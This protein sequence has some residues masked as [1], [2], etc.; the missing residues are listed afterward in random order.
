MRLN[1]GFPEL[2]PELIS[3][4]GLELCFKTFVTNEVFLHVTSRFFVTGEDIPC[5]L[6]TS[7]K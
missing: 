7:A 4:T 2:C 1:K 6:L 5:G 3:Y